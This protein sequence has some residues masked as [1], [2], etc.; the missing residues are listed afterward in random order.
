M[1]RF[2]KKLMTPLRDMVQ[3]FIIPNS[4]KDYNTIAPYKHN[5]VLLYE[6]K[7]MESSV[8]YAVKNFRRGMY[9]HFVHEIWD[10]TV[11]KL[12]ENETW[13]NNKLFLEFGVWVGSSINYFSQRIPNRKFYGFD[14]FEGLQEDWTGFSLTKGHFNLGGN[15]PK[16]NP[17]VQLVKGWFNETLP[18]FIRK[19]NSEVAFLHIDCDTY[20]STKYVLNTLKEKIIPGTYILFDEYIGYPNWEIGEYKAFQEFVS[21]THRNYKYIAFS[22]K[23]VLLLI[24]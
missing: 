8:D 16:V 22:F 17:N 23:Q 20:E 14:S 5:L 18:E 7:L 6:E 2:L 21:E 12:R 19:E 1:K 9:F 15:L 3:F 24:E 13:T 10:Y 11:V 4:V